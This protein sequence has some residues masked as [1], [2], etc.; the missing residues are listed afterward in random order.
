MGF[1]WILAASAALATEAVEV[2]GAVLAT[3]AHDYD[4]RRVRTEM[5]KMAVL[6][7]KAMG[8]SKDEVT[9]QL[10]PKLRMG[11]APA[12]TTTM[13]ALCL[14]RTQAAEFIPLPMGTGLVI[15]ADGLPI[16]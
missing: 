6:T 13:F 7:S 14:P 9:I 15:E 16:E 3:L 2:D 11:Q 1:W 5:S 4:G 12:V 8:C 10:G